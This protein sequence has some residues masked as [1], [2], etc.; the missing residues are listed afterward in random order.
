MPSAPYRSALRACLMLSALLGGGIAGASPGETGSCTPDG[1]L[2]EL[3]WEG[4]GIGDSVTLGE[5]RLPMSP[6]HPEIITEA[7]M[8]LSIQPGPEGKNFRARVRFSF[9]DPK[10][11][12]IPFSF[13]LAVFEYDGPSGRG[14]AVLDWSDGCQQAGRS[15][16]PRQEWEAT[17]DL[18]GSRDLAS[19]GRVRFYLWGSRN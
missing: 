4:V 14:Q 15:L 13:Q 10:P 3:G 11:L 12:G 2:L 7:R 6:T 17:T 16:F 19:L 5:W 8:E 1:I 18:P 9:P